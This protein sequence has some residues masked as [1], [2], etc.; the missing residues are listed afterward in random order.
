MTTFQKPQ[1]LKAALK[2]ALYGPAG[3]GKTFTAL[4]LAEGLARHT[5]KRVAYCDTE[6]GTVNLIVT[7]QTWAPMPGKAFAENRSTGRH[8]GRKS[9]DFL[10]RPGHYS[11]SDGA[12]RRREASAAL[13][14]L[15]PANHPPAAGGPGVDHAKLVMVALFAAQAAVGPMIHGFLAGLLHGLFSFCAKCGLLSRVDVSVN[16]ERSVATRANVGERVAVLGN[17]TKSER[18]WRR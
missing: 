17:A 6:Y 12:F 3:S 16:R 14:A 4:L 5:G 10:G 15:A 9:T 8:A 1:S 18:V 2:M 7:R 13:S 11:R